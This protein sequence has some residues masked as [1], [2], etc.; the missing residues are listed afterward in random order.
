MSVRVEI[1]VVVSCRKCAV[2]LREATVLTGQV[3]TFGMLQSKPMGLV[4]T[5]F[6]LAVAR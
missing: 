1:G 2:I 6:S 3:L 4:V 5:K